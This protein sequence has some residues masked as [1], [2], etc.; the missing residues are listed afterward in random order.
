M[1]LERWMTLANCSQALGPISRPIQP[2]GIWSLGALDTCASAENWSAINESAG[3]VNPDSL[4][5]RLLISSLAV[6]S[7]SSSQ[8]D[9]PIRPPIAFI[10]RAIPPPMMMSVARSSRFSMMN[11]VGDLGAA[12]YG[13]KGDSAACN[14][15]S[16]LATSPSISS[17]KT[18]FLPG[19]F[20]DDRRKRGR[21]GPY[22]KHR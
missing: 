1:V 8:S 6:S 2:S 7:R 12:T 21:G 20:G 19:K 11:F 9:L 4:C 13:D 14:T 17:P 5:L 18:F 22:R 3:K 16:A 10:K 15:F